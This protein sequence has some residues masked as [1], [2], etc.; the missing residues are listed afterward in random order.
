MKHQTTFFPGDKW[1][2]LKIYCGFNTADQLISSNISPL[3]EGKIN[4]HCIDKWFFIRYGD[5]E[6]HLRVRAHFNDS[7]NPLILLKTINQSLAPYTENRVVWKIEIDTYQRELKRYASNFPLVESWFYEESK[8]VSLI[9]KNILKEKNEDVRWQTT[10]A[11]IDG[12]FNVLGYSLMERA[13]ATSRLAKAYGNEFNVDKTVRVQ[14]AQN[15]RNRRKEVADVLSKGIFHDNY[16][17]INLLIQD[18]LV[19]I[20]PIHME[21]I[22]TKDH[23]HSHLHMLCNRIFTSRQR[24]HEFVLFDMMSSFYNSELA[25]KKQI[26]L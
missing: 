18:F 16:P 22:Q 24:L 12:I 13:Q 10:M 15:V 23:L 7:E 14:L 26:C 6:H 9:I 4:S 21:V 25:R 2:F 20:E 5:P 3:L 19:A 1:L 8:M 11:I 17:A